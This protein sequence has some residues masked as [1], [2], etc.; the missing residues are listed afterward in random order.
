MTTEEIQMA[1]L[2]GRSQLFGKENQTCIG[3]GSSG[4][5]NKNGK[6][7]TPRRI[8]HFSD[9]TLEEYSTDEEDEKEKPE[10]D[11]MALVDPKSLTW[12][13]W[14]Y[15]WM[16]YTGSSA[17][18]ACDYVGESLANFLGITSAKYQYEI[19][20]YHRSVEEEKAEKAE[21]DAEMAGWKS[22]GPLSD[23]DQVVPTAS[24]V[25]HPPS[26]THS[27][28]QDLSEASPK[29]DISASEMSVPSVIITSETNNPV[30]MTGSTEQDSTLQASENSSDRKRY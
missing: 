6:V 29:P 20:E 3:M 12:G 8:L 14:M 11:P 21:E 24:A 5:L 25:E 13:P 15:Y 30:E 2:C 22:T 9:G 16:L 27:L 7:K 28:R 1:D 18:Q 17:L 19:D 26:P 23:S 4:T 10:P